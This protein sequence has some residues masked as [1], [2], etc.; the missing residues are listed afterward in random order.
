MAAAQKAKKSCPCGADHLR[1]PAERAL[2]FLLSDPADSV[3]FGS[4]TG[5][6]T[7]GD[8]DDAQDYDLTRQVSGSEV[9]IT[10]TPHDDWDHLRPGGRGSITPGRHS[11]G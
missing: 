4:L 6:Y 5:G 2:Q 7:P 1:Y 8:E 11:H 9:V 3:L 10:L